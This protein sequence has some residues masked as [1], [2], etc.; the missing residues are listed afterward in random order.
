MS[1]PPLRVRS[2]DVFYQKLD[3][4]RS[5]R[6]K[7]RRCGKIFKEAEPCGS[8]IVNSELQGT[9]LS[10][11]FASTIKSLVI[12]RLGA[13]FE[14]KKPALMQKCVSL[15]SFTE[16]VDC[17]KPSDISGSCKSYATKGRKALAIA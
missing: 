6:N 16:L 8:L 14:D 12:N 4:H 3:V 10:F 5:A 9:K 11:S 13:F 2:R 7:R 17:Q 15:P 1:T